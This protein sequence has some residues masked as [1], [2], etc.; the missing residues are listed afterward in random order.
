MLTVLI[1]NSLM[2]VKYFIFVLNIATD[3]WVEKQKLKKVWKSLGY[4]FLSLL[5]DTQ[6]S[7]DPQFLQPRRFQ[8]KMIYD[9]HNSDKPVATG[10][11]NWFFLIILDIFYALVLSLLWYVNLLSI[12]CLIFVTLWNF[13]M[14]LKIFAQLPD[15]KPRNYLLLSI[16]NY[17]M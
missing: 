8:C 12:N 7:N 11:C 6:F 5:S 1:S 9:H 15:K 16:T 10:C 2:K 17:V 4:I 13:H 14:R 3:R